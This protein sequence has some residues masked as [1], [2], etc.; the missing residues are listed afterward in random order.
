LISPGLLTAVWRIATLLSFTIAG[1]LFVLGLPSGGRADSLPA[2]R[3]V[4]V[5]D[6]I[7][8]TRLADPKYFAGATSIGR[9]GHFSP[10]GKHFVVLLR[11]GNVEDNTNE[12]SLFLF[13]TAQA[14]RAP[15]PTLLIKMASSL[16]QGAITDMKWLDDSRT[17]VFLGENRDATSQVY[18]IDTVTRR[19]KKLTNHPTAI[20]GYDITGDGNAMVFVADKNPPSVREREE[21]RR[22]GIVVGQQGLEALLA[23][24]GRQ[25]L[26][27]SSEELFVQ[28]VGKAALRVPIPRGDVIFRFRTSDRLSLA[29]DGR[30]AV[31][32][33]SVQEIPPVWAEY[34][35][36]H[37]HQLVTQKRFKISYLMKDLLLDT[38][39]GTLSPLLNVPED[40]FAPLRWDPDGQSLYLSDVLLPL[41]I[42]DPVERRLRQKERFNVQIMLPGKDIQKIAEK[43]L[44]KPDRG[45]QLDVALVEDVNTPPRIYVTAR[46]QTRKTLLL[47]LNPQFSGLNLGSVETVRWRAVDGREIMGGLYLPQDYVPGHRYPLVLQTHGFNP[48]RFSMDGLEDWSTAFAARPL[49]ANGFVVLQVGAL[50]DNTP[51][52]GPRE[53]AS[54]EG[55]VEYLDK[56]GLIDRERVG[57]VGFSRTTYHVAYTL[58]HSSYQFPAAVLTD[59][60]DGG[61]FN[62]LVFGPRDD[63]F[64]NGSAP[65]GKGLELW[66]KNSPEFNVDHV[67]TALRLQAGGADDGLL[68]LWAWYSAL[69]E[70]DRPVDMVYLPD[71]PHRIVKPWEQ[72]VAEQGLVDWFN[73]WLQGKEDPDPT[74]VEQYRRWRQLRSKNLQ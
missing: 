49:A 10:D 46:D 57:I 14:L 68:G 23:R 67:H 36:E 50:A 37:L 7:E 8:M 24:C 69:R 66:L 62:H 28:T 33:V 6:A 47:D 65:L 58:T 59:G 41:G 40:S 72:M 31:I 26:W 38:A 51:Q 61:Y 29:P 73:F 12:F 2:S 27:D 55:A 16:N 3:Y 56:R 53:M 25:G 45:G 42:S 48:K 15:K 32:G 30:H 43:D 52:E 64:V 74:K 22:N 5:R 1:A 11:K 34:Q 20:G 4:R 60:M 70:L 63:V 9:V 54:Y 21:A 35:D 71:A 13:E 39:N 19:L 17:V 44:P 18:A